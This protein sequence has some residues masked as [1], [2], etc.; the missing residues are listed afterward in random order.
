MPGGI[1]GSKLG[2]AL[3]TVFVSVALAACAANG[4]QTEEEEL[5]GYEEPND[6]LEAPNR[7]V[8]AFNDAVDF[9]VIKPAASTYRFLLPQEFRDLVRNFARHIGLPVV[10]ANNLLQGQWDRAEDSA[11]RLLV[12]SVTLGLGDLVPERHPYH[13]EDFGQTL[14][15]W[16]VDDGFYLVLPILGPSSARDGTGKLVDLFL[17]PLTYVD[18]ATTFSLATR[19]A[20]GVDFR[21]RNIETLEEI[22]RDSVDF[23]ARMRSLY[24]QRRRAQ[25]ENGDVETPAFPGYS[26]QATPGE[27]A[28]LEN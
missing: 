8:F 24:Y 14:A 18:G 20:E 11:A 21:A 5:F 16:G 28:E 1:D 19:A 4:E 26:E 6:P 7:F 25:I 23:Y 2:R 9:A 27:T 17:D 12:N 13:R 10:I 3:A 15:V 22:R